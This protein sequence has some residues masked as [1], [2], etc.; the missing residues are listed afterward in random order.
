MNTSMTNKEALGWKRPTLGLQGHGNF[1]H[2]IL[3]GVSKYINPMQEGGIFSTQPKIQ[4]PGGGSYLNTSVGG[5][6]GE[7]G[8]GYG[9]HK[10]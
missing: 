1:L 6:F 7:Y 9:R 4:F 10:F 8:R 5:V 2:D 3:L